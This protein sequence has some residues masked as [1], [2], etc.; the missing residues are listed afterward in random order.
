MD[1][2]I[3]IINEI[4]VFF[5]ELKSFSKGLNCISKWNDVEFA[6]TLIPFCESHLN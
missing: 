6:R 1:A 5:E 2:S 4:R 3:Q